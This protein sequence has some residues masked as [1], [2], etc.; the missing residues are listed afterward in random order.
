MAV[1]SLI[2]STDRDEYSRFELLRKIIT[3]NIIPNAPLAVV[4]TPETITVELRKARRT[5]TTVVAS[6][7]LTF[8]PGT[9]LTGKDLTFNLEEEALELGNPGAIGMPRL[10]NPF[11][12]ARRGMYFIHAYQGS[13]IGDSP[14]FRLSLISL[15]QFK[16]EY[17]FGMELSSH[18]IRR[19]K[20]PPK[21]ITG[22]EITETSRNHALGFFP[23]TFNTATNNTPPTTGK[24]LSW[25]DGPL[26]SIIT[27]GSY[28]L[29]NSTKTSYVVA[30]VRNPAL[31]PTSHVTEELLMEKD[32]I[33]D[34]AIRNFLEGASNWLEEVELQVFLEPTR[35]V[36]DSAGLFGP[37]FGKIDYDHAGQ[38][39]TMYNR[40]AGQWMNL[41][42]PYPS[43]L[44]MT[45]MFGGVNNTKIL[46]VR[47]EWCEFTEKNG[48]IQFV[49]FS[50]QFLFEFVSLLY[51]ESLR[52][53]L[54]IPN[55]WHYDIWAGL[56]TAPRDLLEVVGK[57][58]AIEIMT[59][60]GQAYKSVI[61]SQRIGRDGVYEG[62]NYTVGP[63]G[64]YGSI[65]QGY[66]DYI[67]KMISKYR[68]VYRGPNM[69][70]V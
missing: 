44:Q 9:Y 5:R 1:T 36:S 62:V 61:G 25:G 58:A 4:A 59:I 68:G 28:I 52:G 43:L 29:P 64:L 40:P 50:Q 21:A 3:V 54:V 26:I 41:Q 55:F 11:S 7:T 51:V 30:R 19:L 22:V 18:E 47:P 6:K 37:E 42:F 53:P 10:F 60:A 67:D 45:T 33:D 13:V 65:I 49:P 63:R 17:L 69:W 27:A 57:K 56:R 46:K 20:F 38:P 39:L 32:V 16:R 48:F 15:E 66:Q 31:L 34:Q 24:F 14:D 8:D 35:V 12:L 70:V 23:L 2:V